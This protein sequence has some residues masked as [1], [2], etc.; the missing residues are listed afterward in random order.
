[1]A[2]VESLFVPDVAGAV[3]LAG[4]LDSAPLSLSGRPTMTYT[5]AKAASADSAAIQSCL[6]SGLA[7]FGISLMPLSFAVAFAETDR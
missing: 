1:M 3:A 5:A 7:G 2:P 4:G 6:A